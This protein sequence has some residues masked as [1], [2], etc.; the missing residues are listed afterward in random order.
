[1]KKILRTHFDNGRGRTID[2]SV[3]LIFIFILLRYIEFDE[4]RL[5]LVHGRDHENYT[6]HMVNT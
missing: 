3:Y 5:F 2:F 6:K 4:I 1:M